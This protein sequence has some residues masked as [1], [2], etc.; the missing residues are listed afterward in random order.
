[1][2][3]GAAPASG[4]YQRWLTAS[5]LLVLPFVVG[6]LV[7]VAQFVE[8]G[9]QAAYEQG[10][11]ARRLVAGQGFTTPVVTPRGLA[12]NPSLTAHPELRQGPLAVLPAALLFKTVGIRSKSLGFSSLGAFVLTAWLAFLVGRALFGATAGTTAC[13]LLCASPAVLAS[14]VTGDGRAWAAPLLLLLWLLLAWPLTGAARPVLVGALLGAV[15]LVSLHLL[16]P[17][18]PAVLAAL[19]TGGG[20]APGDPP[21][22]DPQAPLL[23][24]A[25]LLLVLFPWLVRNQR[26]AGSPLPSLGAYAVM[27][28]T[29]DSPGRGI[30]RRYSDPG[31]TPLGFVATHKRQLL[32]KTSLGGTWIGGT[33][34]RQLDWPLLAIFVL[35]LLQP[36]SGSR[37]R[38]R[39]ALVWAILGHLGWLALGTQEWS[40]LTLWCAPLAVFGAWGLTSRLATQWTAPV[41]RWGL[42][43]QPAALARWAVAGLLLLLALP[44]VGPQIFGG[45]RPQAVEATS[46]EDSDAGTSS[47]N[48]KLLAAR[49]PAAAAVATDDPWRVAWH[50]AR[51]CLWLPQAAEDLEAIHA[52]EP[53]QALYFT[54]AGLSGGDQPGDWWSWAK[55]M[56]Q[57]WSHWQPLESRVPG[58]RLLLAAPGAAT[59]R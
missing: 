48:L 37:A 8:P 22:R 29:E 43:W 58:E 51:P 26:V 9:T 32:Q 50:L 23:A 49:L 52:K 14:S 34:S 17:L 36:L 40:L 7:N 18:L 15:A 12:Y 54:A 35:G 11:T 20:E 59:A 30:E 24:L 1:M 16:W 31:A 33:L 13:L 47:P 21:R 27:S 42:T 56:P 44:G 6:V 5:G 4:A 45:G 57:G 2:A 25:L 39:S 19:W 38:A 53:I 55:Q 41:R 10:A 3:T 46:A 28:F